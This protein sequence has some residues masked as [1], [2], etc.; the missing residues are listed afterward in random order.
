MRLWAGLIDLNTG[1]SW[2]ESLF[3]LHLIYA[4][5]LVTWLKAFRVFAVAMGL[6]TLWLTCAFSFIAA[7]SVSGEWL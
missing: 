5:W 6:L 4:A 2:Y 7:M 3:W 1:L